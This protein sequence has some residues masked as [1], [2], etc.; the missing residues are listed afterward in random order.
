MKYA[1]HMYLVVEAED[2][3]AAQTIGEIVVDVLNS[4]NVLKPQHQ[5]GLEGVIPV[6]D[7]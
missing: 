6:E 5:I 4:A 1:I 7:A 3:A 2:E